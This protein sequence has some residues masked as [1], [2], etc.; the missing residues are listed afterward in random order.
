[1]DATDSMG[2]QMLQMNTVSANMQVLPVQ[3][4]Y[5]QDNDATGICRGSSRSAVQE[6]AG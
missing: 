5:T 6:G 3:C 1:M 2:Q 4:C